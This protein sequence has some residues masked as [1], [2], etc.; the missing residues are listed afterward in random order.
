MIEKELKCRPY[1]QFVFFRGLFLQLVSAGQPTEHGEIILIFLFFF[2]EVVFNLWRYLLHPWFSCQPIELG[3]EGGWEW[4]HLLCHLFSGCKSESVKI[5]VKWKE[6]QERVS[7]IKGIEQ[8]ERSSGTQKRSRFDSSF[9][10]TPKWGQTIAL[11]CWSIESSLAAKDVSY[12]VH[13]WH[14][15]LPI[16]VCLSYNMIHI[17]PTWSIES[18]LAARSPPSCTTTAGS[19]ANTSSPFL[20]WKSASF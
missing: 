14:K 13:E 2:H 1:L 8:A 5:W 10:H 18:S 11:L 17:T 15:K 7:Q 3:G 4:G 19:S 6:L 9:V 16:M 20:I 12:G